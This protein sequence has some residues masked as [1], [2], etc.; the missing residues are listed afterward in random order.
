MN[1]SKWRK[2]SMDATTS[3]LI[4]AGALFLLTIISGMIVSQSPRPLSIGL[5]TLHKL[6]AAGAMVL[7]GIAVN[8]LYKIADGKGLVEAS[9][10]IV[11]GISFL[12][13]IATGALL[14]RE[15]MQLPASV[16]NIHR[17][18]PPLALISSTITVYLLATG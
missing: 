16:L 1:T 10:I 17:I 3:K 5:V 18:A 7:L 11:G 9:L 2:L 14:T 6:I 13:L 12:A 8:H 4:S 15:E